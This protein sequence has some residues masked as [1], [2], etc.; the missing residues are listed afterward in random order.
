MHRLIL[1]LTSMLSAC[2]ITPP[3]VDVVTPPPLVNGSVFTPIEVE[4]ESDIFALSS[5]QK[6]QFLD[7]MQKAKANGIRDDKALYSYIERMLGNF[8]Y[9][10]ATYTATESLQYKKGNCITLAVLVQAYADIIGL[11][12]DYQLITEA[13]VFAGHNDVILLSSHFRTKIYAPKNEDS[14]AIV[15]LRSGI[16][17]DYFPSNSGVISGSATRNDLIAKYY[18]NHGADALLIGDIDAGL[19]YVQQ[20][21]SFNPTSLELLNT[22]AVLHRRVGDYATAK[23]MYEYILKENAEHAV[24]LSNFGVLAKAMGDTP[25]AARIEAQLN[26]INSNDPFHLLHLAQNSAQQGKFNKASDYILQAR[27]IAPYL[28]QTYVEMALLNY[29]RGRLEPAIKE[30][31]SALELTR[32][33]QDRQRYESKYKALQAMTKH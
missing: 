17:I 25:L 13:P 23:S 9:D 1:F 15:M 27:E 18:A 28:P 29:E 5:Q 32:S 3:Q 19:S 21:L 12:T 30:L 7:Y 31:Q 8:T 11:D 16:I 24:A 14:E 6:S 2:A 20:A 26:T 22:A 4:P 10:G 33:H